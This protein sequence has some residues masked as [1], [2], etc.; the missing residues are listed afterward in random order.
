[1]KQYRIPAI[2]FYSLLLV[3]AF[4]LLGCEVGSSDSVTRTMGVDFTGFYDAKDGGG[5]FVEPANSGVRVT[6]LNLRQNGDQLQAIDSNGVVFDGTL[7]DVSSD[8]GNANAGFTLE[9]QTTAGKSVTISGSLSGSGTTA[10]MRGTWIEPDMYAYVL[11]DA[12]I[13]AIP[14]GTTDTVST[15]YFSPSETSFTSS[16]TVAILTDT[17]GATIRYTTDGSTPT[18]SSTAYSSALTFTSTKTLKAYAT[19]SGM[20]DSSVATATYTLK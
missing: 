18:S 1:M 20:T 9:G 17:S 4:M 3:S 2:A 7:N 12:T 5:N 8:S 10:E 15:P 6:S 19:K 11:G 14:T 16:V 13:N